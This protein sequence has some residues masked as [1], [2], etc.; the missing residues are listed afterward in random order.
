MNWIAW[1]A[2]ALALI[3]SHLGIWLLTRRHCMRVLNEFVHRY[4]RETVVPICDRNNRTV[5]FLTKTIAASDDAVRAENVVLHARVRLLR[6]RMRNILVATRRYKR[7]ASQR[8][9]FD[10][11]NLLSNY[12]EKLNTIMFD[13][14]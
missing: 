1:T 5:H 14:R 6:A 8:G 13:K 7:I 10:T 12:V 4:L 9:V 3:V 2:I 11:M